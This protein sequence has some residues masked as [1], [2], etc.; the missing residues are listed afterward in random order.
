MRQSMSARANSYHNAWSESVIGRLKAEMLQDGSFE[1]PSD[2]ETELF[3]YI[4][5][6]Y[7]TRR[8]HSSIG[9]TT[10]ASFEA[11]FTLSN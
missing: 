11:L 2:A 8:R 9:D 6:Y 7:N 3:A 1:T 4:D 10:P 5:S